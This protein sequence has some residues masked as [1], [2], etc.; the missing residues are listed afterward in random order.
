[1]AAVLTA[2]AVSSEIGVFDQPRED[3]RQTNQQS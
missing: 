1:M 2:A 3:D